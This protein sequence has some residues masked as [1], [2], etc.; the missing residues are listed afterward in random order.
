MVINA[1]VKKADKVGTD[2]SIFLSFEYN[3]QALDAIRSLPNK[4]W[5]ANDKQW[6]VP[7]KALPT[8]LD[9]VDW[10]EWHINSEKY[11]ELVTEENVQTPDE[12][13]FK[14]SPFQH[15][16]E[17][18]KYGLA[19]D[20][21]LLGDEQGLGKTKQAIDIAVAKK[22]QKGY[23]HCLIICGVNGLKWNWVEEVKTHS[24]E[25]AYIL[26]QEVKRG[27]L[28]IG[29]NQD[30]LNDLYNIN[31]N[32][33]YFIITNIES[34]RYKEWTGGYV[35]KK[36]KQVKEYVYPITNKLVELC[37]NNEIE[38]VVFDEA[39]KCKNTESNQ[40]EQLLRVQ[41][42]TMI[43]M[44]GTP[45]VN[46]PLDVFFILKWLGYEKHSRY[47]FE[48]RYCIKGGYGG[49]EVIGYRN[50]EELSARLQEI[51][52]RRRK[53]EVL[54][55]P[56]KTYI[57]EYVEMSAKQKK[58]YDEV[59]SDIR[60]NI[61]QIAASPNPL[62]QLIRLRQA[63]GYTGILSS[64]VQ[65]S[66]KLDRM[67]E[68]VADAVENGR[69]V[70]IFSNWTQI[71]D[72][73]RNRLIRTYK[74]GQITGD[75]KDE[76]RQELVRRFQNGELDV[77]LGTIGAMGTGLNLFN[78]TIIIFMDHP[79]NRALYDQCTDRCHRIGQTKNVTIYNLLTKD[80][81]D[82]R[83]WELVTKKGEM[84]DAL[85]DGVFENKNNRELV[86]YLIS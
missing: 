29:S 38:M 4:F 45:L 34:L 79:W 31:A 86:E 11:V 10:A 44:T 5:H 1:D 30:K 6:E 72:E 49:Y 8:L 37:N 46:K 83:I 39:H 55:L 26:G 36:G 47:S 66:A 58:V 40:G 80:T 25:Q 54:D 48:N 14:T 51:M 68:L 41:A 2:Y 61:D 64:T 35:Q 42:D 22:Y 18:F 20:R 24:N 67:E 28:K 57:N 62:S 32:P 12:F 9:K 16:V 56:E 81:I 69:K 75:T 19:H 13:E 3:A 85:V 23:K 71:T 76:D 82:E 21:W 65:E 43:P 70:V 84:S 50:L 77:M 17:G 78:G 73:V 52:L 53:E 74:M 63:T 27:K 15:Q 7:L 59:T 60:M 33:C